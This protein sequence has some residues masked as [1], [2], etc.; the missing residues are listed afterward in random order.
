MATNGPADRLLRS[1]SAR[2]ISSLPVP[3]SPVTSAVASVDAM[4]VMAS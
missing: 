1:W 3:L 2:A 4:R